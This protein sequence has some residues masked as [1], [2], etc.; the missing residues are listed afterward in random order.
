ML[1]CADFEA[2][3]DRLLRPLARLFKAEGAILIRFSRGA[4]TPRR[5][6]RLSVDRAAF[7]GFSGPAFR[8]YA[9]E[10]HAQDPFVEAAGAARPGAGAAARRLRADAP[11][12]ERSVYFN[13]FLRPAGIGD[14]LALTAAPRCATG[15][16]YGFGLHRAVD[17][18]PFG[19]DAARLAAAV[20]PAFA[21]AGAAF[22]LAAA[23][24]TAPSDLGLTRGEA[25]VAEEVAKGLSNREAA[26]RL[27]LS[28]RTVENHLRA[29]YQKAGVSSRAALIVRLGQVSG[30]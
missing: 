30:R 23:S 26:A 2:A 6:G 22:E 15:A 27:G 19:E 29:V 4:A 1:S 20:A 24:P 8:S 28:V 3:D 21:A 14:V 12:V 25:A 13:E 16:V 7:V 17:A 9:A 5:A 18:R 11:G 10:F